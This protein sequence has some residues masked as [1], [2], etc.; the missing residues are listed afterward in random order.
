MG[1]M[2]NIGCV[3]LPNAKKNTRLGKK[4]S[5]LDRALA[6]GSRARAAKYS[7]KISQKKTFFFA[8]ADQ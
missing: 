5:E 2:E 6:A 4:T 3:C 7:K 1:T 8:H